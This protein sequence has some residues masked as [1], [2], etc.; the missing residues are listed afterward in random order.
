[1]IRAAQ[2]LFPQ[3]GGGLSPH[4]LQFICRLAFQIQPIPANRQSC[5]YLGEDAGT[6][7]DKSDKQLLEH[8]HKQDQVVPAG[9]CLSAEPNSRYLGTEP[10]LCL[11]LPS[12]TVGYSD[13][14]H[15]MRGYYD[16]THNSL[17]DE[18][19]ALRHAPHGPQMD[20]R[21]SA[22]STFSRKVVFPYVFAVPPPPDLLPWLL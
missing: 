13:H 9:M 15:R 11:N 16:K 8:L 14:H 21:W 3:K 10:S 17:T 4:P 2:Q 6:L 12:T 7:C 20:P 18:G 1:M 22:H 5:S 19:K